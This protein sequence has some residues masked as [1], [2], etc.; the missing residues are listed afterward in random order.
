NMSLGWSRVIIDLAVPYD[1][2]VDAVQERMLAVAIELASN[3]KWQ[4][5]ILEKPQIWGI[6]SIS[7]DAIVIRLVVK[8]RAGAKDDVARELR[9]RL[10]SALDA[11]NVKLPTLNSVI[12]SGFEGAASVKGARPPRTSPNP[13]AS[14]ADPKPPRGRKS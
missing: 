3:P 10:K 1:A 11:M 14:T 12:L 2:D 9:A 8:T 6:E 7:G 13:I 5:L 4:A